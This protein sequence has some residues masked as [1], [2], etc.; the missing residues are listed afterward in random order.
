M[1]SALIRAVTALLPRRKEG[2]AVW[3]PVGFVRLGSLRR[4]A[5]ISRVFGFDRGHCI[6]RVYIE[7]FLDEFRT[8]VAG[9]VLE[10][11]DNTYTQ[12][13][14][15]D[16]VER[17]DVLH[18][19]AGS[20]GATIVADLTGDD[21]VPLAAFDC[22]VLTQTLNVVYDTR[23][24]LAK[25]RSMLKPGGVL[26]ATAPGISQISRYDMDRWGDYWRFTSLSLRKL[27]EETFPA[28]AVTVRG[29][30]NVLTAVGFLHGLA[31][32]DLPR[33]A[34]NETDVDYEVLL[35]VRAVRPHQEQGS[36]TK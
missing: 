31:E 2:A 20:P 4:T 1:R 21:P 18:A 26:L 35:G 14:G 33:R 24:L 23:A 28:D 19:A 7:A 10:I 9:R 11:A 36:A 3:P 5:P 29:Y 6:D 34:F 8:D 16:R 32:S 15:G 22:I 13:F 25:L 17:S 30:G 27:F 12:R